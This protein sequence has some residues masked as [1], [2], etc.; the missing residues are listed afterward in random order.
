MGHLSPPHDYVT[1]SKALSK[2]GFSLLIP[3][4]CDDHERQ[5]FAY[6]V[7]APSLLLLLQLLLVAVVVMPT[8]GLAA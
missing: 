3:I 4:R 6:D 2:V 8:A 1:A 5:A 7:H